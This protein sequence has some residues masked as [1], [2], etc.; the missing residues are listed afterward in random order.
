MLSGEIALKNNHY[1]YYYVAIDLCVVIT[2]TMLLVSMRCLSTHGLFYSI[3]ALHHHVQCYLIYCSL[4][5]IVR[6]FVLTKWL[7]DLRENRTYK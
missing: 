1:Y 4:N 3:I 7:C 2:Y 6:R 5:F